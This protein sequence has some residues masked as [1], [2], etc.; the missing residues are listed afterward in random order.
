VAPA[1][2]EVVGAAL[3]PP[4]RRHECRPSLGSAG[5]SGKTE[6]AA[7]HRTARLPCSTVLAFVGAEGQPVEGDGAGGRAEILEDPSVLVYDNKGQAGIPEHDEAIG[8]GGPVASRE[9]EGHAADDRL[10]AGCC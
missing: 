2:G 9:E 4:P 7:R 10:V 5:S 1:A 6:R 8:F 3:R